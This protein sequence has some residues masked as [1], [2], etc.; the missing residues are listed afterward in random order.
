[1]KALS[2][3]RARELRDRHLKR[4]YG[5]R[6]ARTERYHSILRAVIEGATKGGHPPHP[7]W[8]QKMVGNRRFKAL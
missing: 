6:K 4:L 8:V 2:P 7:E 1:M 3:R 5:D